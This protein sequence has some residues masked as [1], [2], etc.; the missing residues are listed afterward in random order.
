M[1]ARDGLES[2]LQRL[3]AMDADERLEALGLV[4]RYVGTRKADQAIY[5]LRNDPDRRVRMLARDLLAEGE[6][7]TGESLSVVGKEDE[8]STAQLDELIQEMKA[9][10]PTDRVTALKVLRTINHP[11]AAAAVEAA[12]RDPNRVVRMLAEKAIEDRITGEQRLATR[13]KIE[14]GVMVT[15]E[16][17]PA[18]GDDAWAKRGN[19][20]GPEAVP[21]L[22]LLYVLI[23]VPAAALSL[24]LWLGDQALISPA[25]SPDPSIRTAIEGVIRM[26]LDPFML[27]ITLAL[28]LW[29]TVGG[30]ALLVKNDW[31][32]KTLL[33]YHSVLAVASVLLP[34][35]FAKIIG[36]AANGF[37][38][39]VLSRPSVIRV[40]APPVA[41]RDPDDPDD[42]VSHDYGQTERKVW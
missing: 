20:M 4:R 21:M 15:M 25:S 36:A 12:K 11:R 38:A 13:T 26:P 22:G 17:E 6:K 16:V 28:M 42:S 39:Y 31:G 1:E 41:P 14:N 32:R 8:A 5:E 33:A 27:A 7:R 3:G 10:D 40:F 9:A 37:M 30:G 29:Q 23:G 24:W 35:A 18:K 34:G 2:I 19:G